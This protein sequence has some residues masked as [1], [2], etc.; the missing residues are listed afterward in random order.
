ME[1]ETIQGGGRSQTVIDDDFHST[2]N[3]I[4][5]RG[6]RSNLKRNRENPE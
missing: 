2:A 4:Y 1:E 3:D 6:K 5:N